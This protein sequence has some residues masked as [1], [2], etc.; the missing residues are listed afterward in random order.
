MKKLLIL[1]LMLVCGWANA[2]FV[3]GQV[4][5][6][7]E[8]NSAFAL[9]GKLASPLS[10]FAATTS[11]QLAGIISDESGSG[12]LLFGVSPAITTP[13]ITGGTV[14]AATTGALG[15]RVDNSLSL[16][17]NSFVNQQIASTAATVPI[18]L[19]SGTYNQASLGTGTTFVIFSSGGVISSVLTVVTGG[20]GYVNGDLLLV[21]GG[22][23]DALL[24]VTN[25]VSGV[26]QSGGL[27]VL[28]GGSGY[29]TGATM[30]GI[31]APPGQRSVTFTGT[32][33]G[34]VTFIIQ[35]GTFL[36][37]SRRVQFNNNTTGAFTVTIKL[38]NGA[39]GSVGSG[40]VLPQGTN[41][42]TA[43]LVQT[44]GVNDV[45]FAT[46]AGGIGGLGTM[47]TQNASSVAITGG[48]IN[49]TPIGGVTP[50]S[51]VF[52]SI[53]ASGLITP[54]TT[55][56][57]KGTVLGDNA[58]AGS[59]GEFVTS[60]VTSV[61]LTSGTPA[62]VTSISLTAGDWDVEGNV[63]ITAA[64]TTVF[65]NAKISVNSVSATDAA[66]PDF[67]WL[68][69]VT[70]GVNA[71][72]SNRAPTQRFNLTTTTTIFLVC[73]PTFTTSTATAAG[74]IRARRIR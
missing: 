47:A 15:S 22:N 49:G 32:L 27:A 12:P 18:P 33:T 72:Y 37:A 43:A 3:P 70:F 17:T 21:T 42:S 57:L 38:S 23:S 68:T 59:V 2:Q 55:N 60:S 11:V 52:T 30:A 16:A 63:V 67:S 20:T 51:A 45:W 34:N 26:I 1:G 24:R 19:V 41:N 69:G 7:A 66:T 40:V 5:T 29:T 65:Q 54:S 8:L 9:T 74:R 28:Y 56:G 46:S 4:L 62:N 31:P 39:G 10:Q 50:T 6:A 61:A 73:S 48:S 64:V 36:T 44:D 14:T 25:A 71:T 13:A 35:N 58:I 53:T